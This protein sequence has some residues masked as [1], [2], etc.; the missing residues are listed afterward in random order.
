MDT[1]TKRKMIE[2]HHGGAKDMLDS[3]INIIWGSLSDIDKQRY[4]ETMK[5]NEPKIK[6][7]KRADRN[8]TE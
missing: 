4:I 3:Q 7:M 6:E 5:Q 2:K 8:Q 1:V